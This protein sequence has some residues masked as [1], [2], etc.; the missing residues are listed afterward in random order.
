M[1]NRQEWKCCCCKKITKK[2]ENISVNYNVSNEERFIC[3]ECMDGVDNVEDF[4]SQ[5]L[6][7]MDENINNMEKEN[8]MFF[9]EKLKEL[10]LKFAK[11]GGR[12]FAKTLGMCPSEYY[13]I[14]HGYEP[15]KDAL[16]LY[17]VIE[18]LGIGFESEEEKELT[19]LWNEPFVMQKMSECGRIVHATKKINPDLNEEDFESIEDMIKNTRPATSDECLEI[20]EYINNIAREHNKKA[21]EYNS[22]IQ[23]KTS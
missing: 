21:D 2:S 11:Q 7:K 16:W 18:N 13:R 17:I 14:E 9:G 8:D 3:V 12:N 19:R 6:D 23:K 20:T 1:S 22:G 5:N 4:I 10:R 15:P